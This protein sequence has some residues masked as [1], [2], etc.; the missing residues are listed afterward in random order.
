MS[1][2]ID[3]YTEEELRN[4]V[5]ESNSRAEVIRKLG[6]ST[7]HGSNYKTVNNRIKKYNIDTSHFK[8][9]KNIKRNPENVF[10]KNS[11]AA[12]AVLRRLYFKMNYVEYKCSVCGMLPT[13]Q[14]KPLTL[15]LDHING[16]N[17]DDRIENLRWACPNCNQQFDTTNGKNIKRNNLNKSNSNK[18]MRKFYCKACNKEIG[19]SRTSLCRECWK[20]KIRKVERPSRETLKE[21]IRKKPFSKIGEQY[22]VDGNTIKKWCD[23]EGLPRRKKDIKTYSDSEWLNI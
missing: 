15:I 23:D 20:I 11:T 14:G 19:K 9:C 1:A 8:P 12:Q 22:G 18:I 16:I 21:L 17:N 2:L 6:Y 4:L 13:W 7:E 10:I 3:Q 5:A